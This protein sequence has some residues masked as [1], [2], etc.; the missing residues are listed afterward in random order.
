MDELGRIA[1]HAEHPWNAGLVV[2]ALVQ[3]GQRALAD[4]GRSPTPK[5]ASSVHSG[6]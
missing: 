5:R 6:A 4:G 2:E 3:Q 1:R